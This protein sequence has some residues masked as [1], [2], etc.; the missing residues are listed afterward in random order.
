[1]EKGTASVEVDGTPVLPGAEHLAVDLTNCDREPIHIPGRVQ[2][3]GVLLAMAE[4]SE[5]VEF[6]SA[7]AGEWLD[8]GVE[9]A[10]GS[11]LTE[12]LGPVRAAEVVAAL[13]DERIG[14]DPTFLFSMPARTQPGR[15][16]E[17]CNVLAHRFDGRVILEIERAASTGSRVV[18]VADRLSFQVLHGRVRASLAAL[19]SAQS[20]VEL[21]QVVAEEVRALTGFPRVMM[22]QFDAEWHGRVIAEANDGTME[23]YIHHHF[24]A[25]DIPRQAR[26]LYRLNRVRQIPDV[27]YE[28]VEMVGM[29]TGGPEDGGGRV[30]DLSFSALRSVSPIHLEYLRNMGCGASM[31]VSILRDGR[32][33]GLI[34]CHDRGPRYVGHDVRSACDHLAQVAALQLSAKEQ[35]ED[36]EYRLQLADVQTRLLASMAA[37]EKFVDGMTKADAELLKL[38]GSAGAAILV[39]SE[40]H[41]VGKTPREAEVRGIVE[42]MERSLGEGGRAGGRGARREAGAGPQDVVVMDTLIGELPGAEAFAEVASG[43]LAISVPRFPA[44]YVMWFRPEVVQTITWAGNPNKPVEGVSTRNGPSPSKGGAAKEGTLPEGVRI[45][46]RKSFE[47]WRQVVRERALPWRRV[48]INAAATL[49]D[50]L[51]GIVLKK[52]EELSRL[53]ADLRR[54]NGELEAFSYS[55]SHDLRAPFRHIV[56]YSNLLKKRDEARLDETS[57]RYI[58]TI[59]ES[60]RYAG[61][62]VD[63]LLAFSQMGRKSLSFTTIEMGRLFADVKSEMQMSEAAGRDVTF[64][65]GEMP[66]LPGDVTMLR[67]A[68]RN[69]VSNAVKY[70][71]KTERAKVTVRAVQEGDEWVFSVADNGVGFD[72]AYADKLFGVFQRLHR[73]EEFEGTGIGLANVR[74]IIERHGGRTWAVSEKDSGKADAGATFFFTLPVAANEGAAEV[75]GGA[76]GSATGTKEPGSGVTGFGGSTGPRPSHPFFSGEEGKQGKSSQGKQSRENL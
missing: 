29:S 53:N 75:L 67:L 69:L 49:R 15:D 47:A 64:D 61:S 70:T 66:R 62:L 36:T 57:R 7:N 48:E 76:A 2:P 13:E 51:I 26:E 46:P 17:I 28:P 68:V 22:Y 41:L 16:K 74:R 60:A 72:M 30:L 32:L 5:R 9:R 35:M 37:E 18:G 11:T 52:A 8:G 54:I 44:C 25:S 38:T 19:Q 10:A 27:N 71:R 21:C 33:W 50:S 56:G 1:M 73:A 3:H 6:A 12:L 55:V 40:L 4:G 34:A 31:S 45:H 42:W 43:M 58:E 39:D 14:T 59:A 63:G 24:P 20:V 23:T 65:I